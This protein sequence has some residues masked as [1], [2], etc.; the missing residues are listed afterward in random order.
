M[1]RTM[2]GIG[3]QKIYCQNYDWIFKDTSFQVY[4]IFKAMEANTK[5]LNSN[6]ETATTNF[7][8]HFK[9]H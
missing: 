6:K 9:K 1:V 8:F 7:R 5:M 4:S 3:I 2:I